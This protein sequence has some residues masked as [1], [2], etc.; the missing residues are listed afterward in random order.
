MRHQPL[1]LSPSYPICKPFDAVHAS[2]E[3]VR[4]RAP[5]TQTLDSLWI[6]GT[7]RAAFGLKVGVWGGHEA[8]LGRGGCCW[9]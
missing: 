5:H 7:V 9:G 1:A 3:R 2:A 4:G 6:S 8:P